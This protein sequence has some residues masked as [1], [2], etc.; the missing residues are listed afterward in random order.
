M[1]RWAAA[2][3]HILTLNAK[4]YCWFQLKC[5][6]KFYNLSASFLKQQTLADNMKKATTV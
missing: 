5:Y 3:E 4:G 2:K 1:V 6:K